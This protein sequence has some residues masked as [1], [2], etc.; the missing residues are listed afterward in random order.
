MPIPAHDP[1]I[2][3]VGRDSDDAR[4][5][6]DFPEVACGVRREGNYGT[7]AWSCRRPRATIGIWGRGGGRRWASGWMLDAVD[8]GL[9]HVMDLVLFACL[10][11]LHPAQFPR[12]AP[13]EDV[14]RA[15]NRAVLTR[16]VGEGCS[17]WSPK[18]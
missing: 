7:A 13:P 10:G 15:A 17:R 12:P 6:R 11:C 3:H 1:L 18:V 9:Q 5:T 2:K 14:Q 4:R 8:Q 16:P